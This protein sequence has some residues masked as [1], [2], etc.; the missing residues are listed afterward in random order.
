MKSLLGSHIRI[1]YECPGPAAD[2]GRG[3]AQNTTTSGRR[4]LSCVF[5][6]HTFYRGGRAIQCSRKAR[7]RHFSRRQG[8]NSEKKIGGRRR[9]RDRQK[10]TYRGPRSHTPVSLMQR[11]RQLGRPAS[12]RCRTRRA[13]PGEPWRSDRGR[14]ESKSISGGSSTRK[15]SCARLVCIVRTP[16]TP[17]EPCDLRGTPY[18]SGRGSCGALWGTQEW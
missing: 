2:Q 6:T 11:V 10:G 7:R 5:R 14:L 17:S 12:V 15:T 9:G 3:K 8:S 16:S 1:R 4:R 18:L 13:E